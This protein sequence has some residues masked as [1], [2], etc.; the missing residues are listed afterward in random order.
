MQRERQRERE[1]ERQRE[2]QKDTQRQTKMFTYTHIIY[3]F[4]IVEHCFYC[5]I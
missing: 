4:M 3:L 5:V 1:R 2:A